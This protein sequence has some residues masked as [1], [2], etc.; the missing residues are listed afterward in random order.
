MEIKKTGNKSTTGSAP[1]LAKTEGGSHRLSDGTLLTK[2]DSKQ[3]R[4]LYDD[5]GI[6]QKR[7]SAQYGIP[8]AEMNKF[9]GSKAEKSKK[10]GK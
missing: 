7:L 9:L 10:F 1:V 6:T 3:I 4:F 5:K 2:T 8:M